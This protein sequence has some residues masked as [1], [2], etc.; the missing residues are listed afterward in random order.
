M[1]YLKAGHLP[2]LR[3]CR[4]V[5]KFERDQYFPLSPP[6]ILLVVAPAKQLRNYPTKKTYHVL[7]A[8]LCGREG[9]PSR[10]P[11]CCSVAGCETQPHYNNPTNHHRGSMAKWADYG[12]SAVRYNAAHTHI[13]RVRAHP[14][15]GDTIGAAVEYERAVIVK[16]IKDGY[17]F[18]TIVSSGGNW[19]KDSRS[20]SSRSTGSSTSRPWI[21]AKSRTTSKTCPSSDRRALGLSLA[22]G[23][24]ATDARPTRPRPHLAR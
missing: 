18:I 17:S 15:N 5:R 9:H 4:R 10:W 8:G 1:T 11:F 14:D 22:H 6:V 16:A 3:G 13:N 19:Q 7:F 12:I 23:Q 2:G 21:T 24:S 20:T